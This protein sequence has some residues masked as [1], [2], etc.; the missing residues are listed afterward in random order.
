VRPDDV[1]NSFHSTS[2]KTSRQDACRI[3]RC[4][5]RAERRAGHHLQLSQ[6]GLLMAS[7]LIQRF[8]TRTPQSGLCRRVAA[9][10][11][12]TM[13][14]RPG[15][16]A[17]YS[18]DP[19]ATKVGTAPVVGKLWRE[20][21]VRL[22]NWMRAFNATS[23]SHLVGSTR[24][25]GSL[26]SPSRPPPSSTSHRPLCPAKHP[27]QAGLD[28]SEFNPEAERGKPIAG[29]ANDRGAI[30]WIGADSESAPTMPGKCH[31]S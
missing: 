28:R 7:C 23:R 17:R 9:V 5:D 26:G 1:Y 29:Y 2:A 14:G 11:A 30:Q 13:A 21:I 8:V 25:F 15:A 16:H 4:Q 18:V 27:H 31:R 22:A 19:E 12:T 20:P 10:F 3:K 24:Y 6:R